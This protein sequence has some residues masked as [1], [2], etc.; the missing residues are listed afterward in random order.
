M[1]IHF[2]F[3]LCVS[4]KEGSLSSTHTHLTVLFWD[5]FVATKLNAYNTDYLC[6]I[7][8]CHP[9]SFHKRNIVLYVFA[10]FLVVLL[11]TFHMEKCWYG[12][13]KSKDIVLGHLSV[14]VKYTYV[15]IMWNSIFWHISWYILCGIIHTNNAGAHHPLTQIC[16]S[17][18]WESNRA[19]LNHYTFILNFK[20]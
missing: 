11:Q 20:I 9:V 19:E 3:R 6:Y 8:V 1:S 10:H 5:P 18:K 12:N 13:R 16:S 14:L 17:F 4:D 7:S 2:T 15:N